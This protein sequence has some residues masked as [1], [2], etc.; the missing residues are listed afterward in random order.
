MDW[1]TLLS[2]NLT[3]AEQVRDYLGLS[4]EQYRTIRD[5]IAVFP[6]SVTKYYMSLIDPSDPDDPIRRMAVPDG[7]AVITEG[8]LDT[9]GEISN[10]RFRGLQHK[11]RETA[12]VLTTGACAMFC[13][14]CFRRRFVGMENE[15][16]AEDIE[17]VAAYIREHTEISNVLLSGGDFFL[18]PTEKIAQWLEVLSPMD[19]LDLIRCGTRTPVTFPQRILTDPGLIDTL[20]IYAR[21]KQIYIVTHFNHPKELTDESVAAIRSLQ[22]AGLTIKN[23]T[24]LLRGVNDDPDTLYRLLRKISSVGIVQ[25]YIFQCRPV[26][27]VK[28][29]FSIPLRQGSRIV[30]D[31]LARQN[32]LGKSADY[33]ISHITG[34]IRVLG[35]TENGDLLFQY[36]QAKDPSLLGKIFS[37]PLAKDAV[38]LPEKFEI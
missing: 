30:Q 25:H 23:Q 15:E 37:L 6:M 38:W 19:H 17:N 32:G 4:N 3:T 18:L 24:V 28:S 21:K 16:V 5:E 20:S 9:S 29:R 35:E 2:E 1:Q 14:H 12:L 36:K 10:T 7:A 31:T 33:T 22:K 34:K 27:G 13:R 8:M 26:A 11:Y